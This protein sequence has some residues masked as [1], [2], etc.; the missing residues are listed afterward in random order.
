MTFGQNVSFDE[1]LPMVP[2]PSGVVAV[3]YD[4]RPWFGELESR[5]AF[6]QNRVARITFDERVTDGYNV[7]AL[8]AGWRPTGPIHVQA[9]VENL[10]DTFYQEHLAISDLAARGR[11]VY[12]AIVAARRYGHHAAPDPHIHRLLLLPV[13]GKG[14]P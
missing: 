9:G 2:P 3:R 13:Q 12:V 4:R 7:L 10:L 5:W 6:P 8:R 1:P 11:S 14:L